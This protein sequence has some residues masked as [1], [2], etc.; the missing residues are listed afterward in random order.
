MS[1]DIDV[2]R[3]RAWRTHLSNGGHLP[4][5]VGLKLLDSHEAQGARIAELEALVRGACRGVDALIHWT[6]TGGKVRPHFAKTGI[7]L[8]AEQ[9]ALLREPDGSVLLTP[10]AAAF[11]RWDHGVSDDPPADIDAGLAALY[12]ALGVDRG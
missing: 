9:A 3:L 6:T 11:V 8:T 2:E 10:E 12:D 4:N 1:A 5:H 7:N